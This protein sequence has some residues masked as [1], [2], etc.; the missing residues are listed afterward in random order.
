MAVQ[1]VPILVKDTLC[2]LINDRAPFRLM[3]CV[4][5][6]ARLDRFTV[7]LTVFHRSTVIRGME[8]G[9]LRVRT[10]VEAVIR[11]VHGHECFRRECGGG[12]HAE[13]SDGRADDLEVFHNE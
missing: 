2:F 13:K 1:H 11:L 10:F 4:P 3:L 7:I 9:P 8:R 12:N 6:R 5:H